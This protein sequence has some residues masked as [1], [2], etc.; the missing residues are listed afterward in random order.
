[1]SNWHRLP[2]CGRLKIYRGRH[3]RR[4]R[5]KKQGDPQRNQDPRGQEITDE[6][7]LL[8]IRFEWSDKATMLHLGEN[9]ARWRNLVGEIQHFYLMPHIHSKLWRDI[10]KGID[11]HMAKVEARVQYEEMLRPRDL[12]A[13]TPMGVPY[14]EEQLMAMVRKGK[15][16]ASVAEDVVRSD[17]RMS[18]ML[19][20]LESQHEIGGG[21]ESGSCGGEDDENEDT[22][23]DEEILGHFIYGLLRSSY[24]PVAGDMSPGKVS[25]GAGDSRSIVYSVNNGNS[26]P[27]TCRWEF[28]W[29]N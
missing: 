15:A 3:G 7:G 19:A 2:R 8:E 23:G 27:M 20:Q 9:F 5:W 29:D 12:G 26:F 18:D 6:Y 25:L 13:N 11:Q 4:Q 28:S 22:G 10:K 1:M 24:Y 16:R 17:D 14:T 21:S